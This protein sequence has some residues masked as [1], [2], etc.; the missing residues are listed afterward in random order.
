MRCL[1]SHCACARADVW[2]SVFYRGFFKTCASSLGPPWTPSSGTRDVK[3]VSSSDTGVCSR[4]HS[5]PSLCLMYRQVLAGSSLL[6][7]PGRCLLVSTEMPVYVHALL[8]T[9]I[10]LCYLW[11]IKYKYLSVI[12]QLKM[13]VQICDL[14][15]VPR[16]AVTSDTMILENL[17]GSSA[18]RTTYTGH[19]TKGMHTFIA[20]SPDVEPWLLTN[21]GSPCEDLQMVCGFSCEDLTSMFKELKSLGVVVKEVTNELRQ[22]VRT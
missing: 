2:T 4:V 19:K 20:C 18:I 1:T 14:I 7:L 11:H 10:F 15:D 3:A 13:K 16:A 12:N 17:N 5:S 21:T 8:Q 22:L 6:S 9:N